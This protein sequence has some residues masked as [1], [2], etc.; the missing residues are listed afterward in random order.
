MTQG[1]VSVLQE[2]NNELPSQSAHPS[3]T[4]QPSQSKFVPSENSTPNSSSVKTN[5]KQNSDKNADDETM[6]KVEPI[7]IQLSQPNDSDIV[8]LGEAPIEIFDISDEP[9]TQELFEMNLERD[10]AQIVTVETQPNVS[11]V[12]DTQHP[13]FK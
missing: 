8:C 1:E 7:F 3:Q 10:V 4:S 6:I 9:G 11:Q 13:Q 12:C 2:Y 5:S